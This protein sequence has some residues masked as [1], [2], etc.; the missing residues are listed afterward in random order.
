MQYAP[1]I[2]M[3]LG[4]VGNISIDLEFVTTTSKLVYDWLGH[5]GS[6]G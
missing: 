3:L 2:K 6:G 4:M 5:R 1:W